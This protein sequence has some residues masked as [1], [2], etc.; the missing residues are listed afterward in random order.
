MGQGSDAA[1]IGTESGVIKAWGFRRLLEGRQWDGQRI[2]SIQG[3]PKDWKLDAGEDAQQIE[4]DD[5]GIPYEGT[6]VQTPKGS[7]AGER[8]CPRCRDMAIQRPG[9]SSGW[10]PHTPAC[11]NI[12][13]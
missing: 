9:P 4:M 2:R 5:G 8:R 12:M 3:S 10:A 6:G 11:R 7:R 13:E 1:L